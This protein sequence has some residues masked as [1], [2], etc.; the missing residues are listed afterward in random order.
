MALRCVY[1]G[2]WHRQTKEPPIRFSHA[3][4][5]RYVLMSKN[6]VSL[7]PIGPPNPKRSRCR[8]T[9]FS[10]QPAARDYHDESTCVGSPLRSRLGRCGS[11]WQVA[12]LYPP[13]QT[14][15]QC[16]P[17]PRASSSVRRE[18]AN[19]VHRRLGLHPNHEV[20]YHDSSQ[21]GRVEDFH[22][23]AGSEGPRAW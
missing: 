12:A 5:R 16:G 21:P 18:Y 2:F 4:A 14:L 20:Q 7:Y 13:E 1:R 3:G 19:A 23:G 8:W 22:H 11:R 10:R 9:D 17:V 6:Y 15:D